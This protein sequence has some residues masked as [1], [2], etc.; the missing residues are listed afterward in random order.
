VPERAETERMVASRISEAD[1]PE[2]LRLLRDPR[3]AATLSLTGQPPSEAAV[4]DGLIEAIGHWELHGFG[5]WLLRDRSSAQLVG[6]G[7]LQHTFVT[8]HAEV[9]VAWAIIPEL[10]GR[11]LATELARMSI[12]AAF[13]PLGH[14]EVIA[15]TL[16]DNRA[17]RRVMEKT[18]FGFEAVMETE[19]LTQ[20]LYR[21]RRGARERGPVHA[22]FPAAP[23]A[24]LT[25]RKPL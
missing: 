14:P 17:S 15:Y 24:T 13:G 18:G 5:L 20:V 12:D 2:L 21:L 3:V 6:R 1:L 8:G 19:G 23:A 9:E 4:S 25:S 7:G 10:W 22:P 16:P 11:G